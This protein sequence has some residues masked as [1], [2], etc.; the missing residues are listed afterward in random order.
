MEEVVV[1]LCA[2]LDDVGTDR[3]STESWCGSAGSLSARWLLRRDVVGAEEVAGNSGDSGRL[4]L[5]DWVG[6]YVVT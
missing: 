3:V 1:G 4:R 6:G 2:T 5:E